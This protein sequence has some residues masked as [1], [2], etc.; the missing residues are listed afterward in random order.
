MADHPILGLM[1]TALAKIKEMVDVNT[2]IGDPI[3]TPDG[4]VIL[5][6]S[7]VCFGFASGGSDYPP[8]NG[9]QPSPNPAFGGGSGAGISITPI[10]F[11]VCTDGNVKLIQI[12]DNSTTVDR[13][14]CMVPE[15]VDKISSKFKKKNDSTFDE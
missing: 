2:I 8:K 5:P 6:V 1:S 14:V 13:I 12:A 7:K 11:L 3:T 4:T 10:A 9:M 15:L